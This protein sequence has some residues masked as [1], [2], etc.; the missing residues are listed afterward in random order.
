MVMHHMVMHHMLLQ[1]LHEELTWARLTG[2]A[3]PA[4]F[5]PN[6][7]CSRAALA[8][9]A[10]A[11]PPRSFDT[12]T[13]LRGRGPTQLLPSRAKH[14]AAASAAIAAGKHAACLSEKERNSLLKQLHR[15]NKWLLEQ[16]RDSNAALEEWHQKVEAEQEAR[17][18][19][20]RPES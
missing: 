18:P 19:N 14:M 9:D 11:A 6:T 17:N 15:D 5:P 4:N 12:S 2:K 13:A 16:L 20:A 7:S 3:R 1:A 8:L 10:L